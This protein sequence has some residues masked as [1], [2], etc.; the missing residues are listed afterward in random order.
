MINPIDRL[1][2]KAI[3]VQGRFALNDDGVAGSVAAALLTSNGNIYTGI[4]ID[5]TCGIGTCAEH[6]AVA[7]MLKHRETSIEMIVAV[8]NGTIIPPCGRCRELLLQIDASNLNTRILL[9]QNNSMTLEEMLPHP[10]LTMRPRNQ[11]PPKS[12]SELSQRSISIPGGAAKRLKSRAETATI[13]F[14]SLKRQKK[15]A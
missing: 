14:S 15:T 11:T 7:E 12:L 13:P 10:W 9:D 6:A 2:E 4:S 8:K 3:E 1:I 5:I